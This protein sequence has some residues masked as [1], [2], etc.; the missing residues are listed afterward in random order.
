MIDIQPCGFNPKFPDRQEFYIKD[1]EQLRTR[2]KE[3]EKDLAHEIDMGCQKYVSETSR[4]KERIT[5]LEGALKAIR[6]LT[7]AP[8][9]KTIEKIPLRNMCDSVLTNTEQRSEQHP[10]FTQE[11]WGDA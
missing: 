4:L 7:V 11:N 3:L 10:P 1:I 9:I 2:I 6:Y 5:T 8:T